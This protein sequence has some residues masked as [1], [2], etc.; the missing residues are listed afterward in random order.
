[1][2]PKEIFEQWTTLE[3]FR[4]GNYLSFICELNCKAGVIGLILCWHAMMLHWKSKIIP[5]IVK[6]RMIHF[7]FWRNFFKFSF[8]KPSQ[9]MQSSFFPEMSFHFAEFFV[10]WQF[11]TA[12]SNF[13]KNW[14]M[15]GYAWT[16]NTQWRAW[17]WNTKKSVLPTYS[18]DV[19][20]RQRWDLAAASEIWRHF[21]GGN[22]RPLQPINYRN[23]IIYLRENA[24]DSHWI[25]L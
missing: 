17:S 13:F 23:F 2:I 16:Q 15:Y 22:H 14:N 9:M 5:A 24:N 12:P 10:S 20:R 25:T 18:D 11:G 4:L 21:S 8:S 3:G 7:F 6:R 1:M 19:I